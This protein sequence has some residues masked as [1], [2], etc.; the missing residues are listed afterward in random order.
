MTE[1]IELLILLANII[2]LGLTLK[3]YTE[4]V[5]YKVLDPTQTKRRAK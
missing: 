5:K 3:L 1:L 2:V 4:Q